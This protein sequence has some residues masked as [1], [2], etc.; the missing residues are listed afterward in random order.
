[1][2]LLSVVLIAARHRHVHLLGGSDTVSSVNVEGPG[3]RGSRRIARLIG[4]ARRG[5]TDERRDRRI[6]HSSRPVAA[7]GWRPAA[8]PT[9]VRP[10]CRRNADPSGAVAG[11]RGP[12]SAAL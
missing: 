9:P 12:A 4:P 10:C 1:S 3:V 5:R 2:Q 11:T 8:A 7:G 6:P